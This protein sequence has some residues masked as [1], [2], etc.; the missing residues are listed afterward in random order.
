[1]AL[2]WIGGGSS[3]A[4]TMLSQPRGSQKNLTGPEISDFGRSEIRFR[5][6]TSPA[7]VQK[8]VTNGNQKRKFVFDHRNR[9]F[10]RWNPRRP[11]AA[12]AGG[13]GDGR[14]GRGGYRRNPACR[15]P[16]RRR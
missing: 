14:R 15:R 7:I 6:W 11:R 9:W 10:G 8:S 5:S 16:A 3:C 12:W 13:Y 2:A 4:A 1:M